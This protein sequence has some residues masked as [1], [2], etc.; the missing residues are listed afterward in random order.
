MRR[1]TLLLLLL[2]VLSMMVTAQSEPPF[3]LTIVHTN[4]THAAHLPGSNGNGGVAALAA[5]VKQIRGEAA[6]TLFLDAGDRFT[7][8][9]FHTQYK[10]QDQVQIMNL[11]GYNAM[12]LGN[13]E[14]DNGDE[15][16]AAFIDGLNFPAVSA[17]IDFSQSELLNG[18]VMPY[19]ILDAGGRQ[20]GV[21]GLTTAETAF[22]SNAG[23]DI[24]FSDDYAGIVNEQAAILTEQGVNII[25]VVMHV[26][27]RDA[28]AF[29]PNLSG[30]DLVV[31]GHSHTL[32]SNAYT[33]AS[34]KYPQ[35][36]TNAAGEKIY[37]VQAGANTQYV[38]RI[39]LAFNADG[40]VT[41]A[42]GDTIS[43]SKYITPDEEAAALVADLYEEVRAL[44]DQPIGAVAA[45]DFDG[46]R[47]VCRVEECTMG[48][49]I[50]DAMRFNSG[51]QIAL[52]NG[53]GVRA[54]LTAGDIT[55]GQALTV[56]PFSNL[57]ATLE[58]TGANVV[59]ALEHG[60]GGVTATDG[61]ISRE[62]LSGRFPQ[63]SGI[64]F[65]YDPTQE[66]GSRVSNV[67]IDNGDGTFSPIDP[68]VVYTVVTNGFMRTGGDGYSVLNEQ[69]INPYDF[70]TLDV[71]ATVAYMAAMGTVTPALEGRITIVGATLPALE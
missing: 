42:S 7:G 39:D 1:F 43:L 6:N 26:G 25:I 62:G 23:D 15:V 58:L 4:D 24:V 11:L 17:N 14:F 61:V 46:R 56:Q 8:T 65:S 59:V 66:V 22:I 52:M 67:E 45:G 69:A 12:A 53:G 70:G 37:Y 16:L 50:A 71:D 48:N 64:R 57:L 54:G 32:Y 2:S 10:G 51:A 49:L 31:D 44:A 3:P 68:D 9:L 13:H 20:I 36:F 34:G 40:V 33:G 63:V 5:V 18:K 47:E 27:I 21:I 60:V 55:L 28:E 29:I 35:E 30:V 41:S 38:G 19:A